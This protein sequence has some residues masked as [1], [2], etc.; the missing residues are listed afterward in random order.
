MLQ[1]LGR[2]RGAIAQYLSII[3]GDDW[4]DDARQ[5]LEMMFVA[6]HRNRIEK[7]LTESGRIV[8]IE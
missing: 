4:S 6:G 2:G 1:H 5:G 8:A 3:D 7:K